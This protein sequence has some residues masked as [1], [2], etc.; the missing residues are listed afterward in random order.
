MKLHILLLLS[1]TVHLSLF[2][3]ETDLQ[4]EPVHQLPDLNI[5][6]TVWE[7]TPEA[8]PESVSLLDDKELHRASAERF[9]D[10]LDSLPNLTATGGTNGARY[11]QI[12]GTGEN[13][14]FEGETPDLSVR[15]LIDDF[16]FTGIGGVATLF[17]VA[18]VEVVRGAQ[19]GAYGVSASG[20]IIKITTEQPDLDAENKASFTLGENNLRSLN[21]ASGGA[22]DKLGTTLYRISLSQNQS[23]GTIENTALKRRDTNYNENH[24]S[25][26]KIVHQLNS[27]AQIDCALIY[28]DQ[29]G[30]YDEWSLNNTRH[31]SQS[32]DPGSDDQNSKG[33]SLKLHSDHMDSYRIHALSSFLQTDSLYSYDS[34]WGDFDSGTSGYDG[35]LSIDRDRSNFTQEISLNSKPHSVGSLIDQWTLG[36]HYNE[37]SEASAI[38]Y[39]DNFDEEG[40]GKASVFSDYQTETLSLFGQFNLVIRPSDR[41][42]IGLRSE[43][44][45]VDF[46]SRTLNNVVYF[47]NPTLDDGS[48]IESKD[49]LFGAT[50]NYEKILSERE[51]LFLSYRRGYKAAGANS[52]SFRTIDSD[53]PL[54]YET[55][56]RDTFELGYRFANASNRYRAQLNLFHLTRNNAQLR[57]SEGSGGFFNYFTSNAGQAVHYGL[58]YESQ[59]LIGTNWSLQSN[60]STLRAKL[61]NRS[62][63]LSNAPTYQYAFLLSYAPENGFYTNLGVSGS[64]A[65]YESNRHSIERDAFNTVKAS[66]GYQFNGFDL[67]FWV[68]NLFDDDYA[69]RIFYF[70]NFHPE[71]NYESVERSY[72]IS[73]N[74]TNYGVR[75]NYRW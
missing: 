70:D 18:Q 49:R 6:A 13:S 23:D 57:D 52:T 59:W 35:F 16:D 68:K 53:S 7:N 56:R 46:E 15:F 5:T 31:Q 61:K 9:E 8:T 44:H 20:G 37:I 74:P 73:A 45:R 66:L 69:K 19:S 33:I 25:H 14:Q 62:R 1:I 24:L 51:R 17:D 22:L 38:D 43:Y 72:R 40:D 3:A 64:D 29:E 47:G 67:S 10:L 39:L 21:Y 41:L 27:Q 26:L 30:G 34:D 63:D 60:L 65:Y 75:L 4:T 54:S 48:A 50:V 28:A 12:R 42:S 2:S 36:L 11:F 58:E 32:D 71:D 55:E